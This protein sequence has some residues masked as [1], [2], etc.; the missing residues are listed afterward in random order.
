MGKEKKH[1]FWNTAVTRPEELVQFKVVIARANSSANFFFNLTKDDSIKAGDSSLTL[2]EDISFSLLS[3]SP[4]SSP[5]PLL[6]LSSLS[7]LS[8]SSLSPLSPSLSLS[9]SLSLLSLSLLLS[10]TPLSLSL[11]SLKFLVWVN[12]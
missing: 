6:S 12:P 7:L 9:L 10:L 2:S 4:L 3:L 11:L 5:S 1:I 8:L